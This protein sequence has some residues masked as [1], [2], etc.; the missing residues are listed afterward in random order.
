MNN[1]VITME[2]NM[3]EKEYKLV[4]IYSRWS[5]SE[6]QS[7]FEKLEE[8]PLEEIG[9]MTIIKRKGK[10]TKRTLCLMKNRAYYEL[11]NRGYDKKKYDIDFFMSEYKLSNYDYP[12]Q[13]ES[14]ILY[15]GLPPTLTASECREQL[16]E[17]LM[18]LENFNV[19][20]KEKC[21]IKIPLKSRQTD[22]HKG[23]SFIYFREV[24]IKDIIVVKSIL[25]DS[26]WFK[27]EDETYQETMTCYWARKRIFKNKNQIDVKIKTTDEIEKC[28]DEICMIK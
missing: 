14:R 20:N 7:F 23:L 6:I 16:E 18:D 5:L 19:I 24:E 2:Q 10:E 27:S 28:N 13:N 8:F 21:Q 22:E 26:W 25:N 15:V 1:E 11:L 17:K 12:K 9:P 4:L 3:E